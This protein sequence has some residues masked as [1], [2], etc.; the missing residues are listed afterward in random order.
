MGLI[1]NGFSEA[2]W[3]DDVG[4]NMDSNF[5]ND[6]VPWICALREITGTFH[7]KS[8]TTKARNHVFT[9][10]MTN[11]FKLAGG[12]YVRSDGSRDSSLSHASKRL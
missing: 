6:E 9:S 4:V 7:S 2:D 5:Q 10:M 12:T 3:S 8:T 11:I 1:S